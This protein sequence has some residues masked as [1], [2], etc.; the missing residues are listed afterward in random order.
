MG[1]CVYPVSAVE[2]HRWRG[3][4]CLYSPSVHILL[5]S[6]QPF[7]LIC[8]PET[9]GSPSLSHPDIKIPFLLRVV[10]KEFSPQTSQC[11]QR[12]YRNKSKRRVSANTL[13]PARGVDSILMN[14]C[15]QSKQPLPVSRPLWAVW[16]PALSLSSF[17][18]AS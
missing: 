17:L 5:K 16:F 6:N 15:F 8:F 12:L 1:L 7:T 10:P 9:L 14:L 18:P 2:S 13:T 4:G 3:R 11:R